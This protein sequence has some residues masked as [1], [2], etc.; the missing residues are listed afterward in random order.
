MSSTVDFL[1]R[2]CNLVKDGKEC[3]QQVKVVIWVPLCHLVVLLSPGDLWT[4]GV[5]DR[6][7][8]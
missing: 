5:T 4:G 3:A 7:T 6:T 1:K 2:L 8:W